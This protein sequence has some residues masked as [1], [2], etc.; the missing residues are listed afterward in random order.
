[1]GAESSIAAQPC[2]HVF[3]ISW[4]RVR[5]VHWSNPPH[6][7]SC[8]SFY[9]PRE[10]TGYSRGKEKNEKEPKTF[11]ITR[12][13]FSFSSSS[14]SFTVTRAFPWPIKG[15]TGHPI[16]GIATHRIDSDWNLSNPEPIRTHKH[17]VEKRPSSQHPF[18]PLTRDLGYVPLA[19]I[20]NPYH[21]LLVLVTR[22]AAIN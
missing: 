4:F 18:A 12:P 17:I 13:F 16:K 2:A 3:V 22:A 9:R 1:M 7:T 21:E 11:R 15:K 10:S 6:G 20:C 8:F 19:T 5:W 14:F